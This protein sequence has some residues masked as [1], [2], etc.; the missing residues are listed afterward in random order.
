MN[1]VFTQKY[2]IHI[3]LASDQEPQFNLNAETEQDK[4]A[5]EVEQQVVTSKDFAKLEMERKAEQ[6]LKSKNALS[7][8]KQES[9]LPP[10]AVAPQA[11]QLFYKDVFIVRYHPMEHESQDLSRSQLSL[12]KQ[13]TTQKGEAKPSK[14]ISG[15]VQVFSDN[16]FYAAKSKG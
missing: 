13:K 10:S 11:K 6:A 14:G 5:I 3:N 16:G 9:K 7:L 4:E 8:K 12:K 15:G 2:G 1:G